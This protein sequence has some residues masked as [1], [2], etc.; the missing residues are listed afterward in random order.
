MNNE[1]TKLTSQ[2]TNITVAIVIQIRMT[3][4]VSQ[5][6]CLVAEVYS[7]KTHPDFKNVVT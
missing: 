6:T 7:P 2:S 1:Y 3:V 5:F 4:A